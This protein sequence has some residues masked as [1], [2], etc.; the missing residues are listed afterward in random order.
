MSGVTKISIE[1]IIATIAGAVIGGSGI[2]GLLFAYMRRFIDKRLDARE[3]EN[4]K[5][6]R[7]K[8]ERLKL[9]DEL[10]AATGKV[11][12]YLHKAIVTG[13][14]NGD[15]EDAWTNYQTIRTKKED[16]DRSILIDN[17]VETD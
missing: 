1:T 7:L 2:C 13:Q 17:I 12:F 8:T 6:L 16:F 11:I 3:H 4:A 14:H 9:E 5:N 15:L 10:N